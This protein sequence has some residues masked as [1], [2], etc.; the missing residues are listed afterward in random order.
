MQKLQGRVTDHPSWLE[1]TGTGRNLLPPVHDWSG[2]SSGHRSVTSNCFEQRQKQASGSFRQ[3]IALLGLFFH[4]RVAT[5]VEGLEAESVPGWPVFRIQ[6]DIPSYQQPPPE[7]YSALFPAGLET[8]PRGCSKVTETNQFPLPT[9]ASHPL[10]PD[11]H[12]GNINST[13][14]WANLK[15]EEQGGPV[16]IFIK[17]FLLRSPGECFCLYHF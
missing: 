13:S 4:L 8:Q 9:T 16:H 3:E 7:M 12:Q 1:S 6:S 2:H 17:L 15:Q 11:T 14:E 10:C 5:M